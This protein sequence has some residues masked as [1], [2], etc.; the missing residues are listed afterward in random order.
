MNIREIKIK[1]LKAT[2]APQAVWRTHCTCCGPQFEGWQ[3]AY[4][5]DGQEIDPNERYEQ[6]DLRK[7]V[8]GTDY[9]ITHF[10]P[11]EPDMF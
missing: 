2:M 5:Y 11:D 1:F 9:A 8:L 4:F 10:V 6:V 7:L 3:D